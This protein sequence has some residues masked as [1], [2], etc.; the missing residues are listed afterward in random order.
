MAKSN[1]PHRTFRRAKGVAPVVCEDTRGRLSDISRGG[2][3]FS[4]SENFDRFP[5]GKESEVVIRT[6]RSDDCPEGIDLRVKGVIRNT[7]I[8]FSTSRLI[9]GVQFK[10]FDDVTREQL[11]RVI[12]YFAQ[13]SGPLND[14]DDIFYVSKN[15]T[16]NALSDKKKLS[17]IYARGISQY[18]NLS[19]EVQSEIIRVAG[20]IQ[21]EM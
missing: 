17:D 3:A 20:M 5:L 13:H 12:L 11:H 21:N 1:D 6:A 2:M 7:R 18:E 10:S 4:V 8:D 9:V 16:D 19:I 15:K 14:L